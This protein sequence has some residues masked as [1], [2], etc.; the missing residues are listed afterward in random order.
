MATIVK[1][2]TNLYEYDNGVD[3]PIR[4]SQPLITGITKVQL[5]KIR[6]VESGNSVTILLFDNE[7]ERDNAYDFIVPENKVNAEIQSIPE[8][9]TVVQEADG[10]STERNKINYTIPVG[11]ELHITGW[12]ATNWE[13]KMQIEFQ[14]NGTIFDGAG[15]N[16]DGGVFAQRSVTPDVPIASASAGETVR[17]RREQGDSGKN[18]FASIQGYLIDA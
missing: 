4:F 18:W 5:T 14:I 1:I 3:E 10:F 12:T 8:G 2:A 17:A 15:L 7:T 16:E 11:K 6:L 9:A 13:G